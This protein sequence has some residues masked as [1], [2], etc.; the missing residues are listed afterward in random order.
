MNEN[1]TAVKRK[2]EK[3]RTKKHDALNT[4]QGSE[5]YYNLYYSS[6]YYSSLYYVSLYYYY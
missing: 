6:L 5:G 3:P 1:A 4:V 2:Y